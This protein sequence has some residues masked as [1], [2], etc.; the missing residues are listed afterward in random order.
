M[1]AETTGDFVTPVL[2]QASR[3]TLEAI[4]KKR[5]KN[6]EAI[7]EENQMIEE[8]TDENKKKKDKIN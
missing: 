3:H 6:E 8:E 4:E 1:I 2:N 7:P 5:Q